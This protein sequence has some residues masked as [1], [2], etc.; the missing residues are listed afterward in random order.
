MRALSTFDAQHN[1]GRIFGHWRKVQHP[2]LGEVEV[3]GFDPR[4]GIWNPPYERLAETC[5]TQSAAFLRVAALVPRVSVSVAGIDRAEGHT[6]IHIRVANH[7][8]LGTCGLPSAKTLPHAEPLRLTARGEGV[9][10]I[11]PTEAVLEIGHLNGWGGGLHGG[12][13][14][15]SPWTTGNGHER[16]VT[17]VATGTGAVHV[18]VGSCRVGFHRLMIEVV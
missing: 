16:F 2:Q 8:Y 3:N 18:E 15:F 5:R 6:R 10:L 11:A 12:P 9:T 7:G 1:Q 17:L 4:V 13:S 14:V